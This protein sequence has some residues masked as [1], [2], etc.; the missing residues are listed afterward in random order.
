D[1]VIL[2]I[3]H[4]EVAGGVQRYTPRIV[5]SARRHAR[6]ADDLERLVGRVED[7]DS[8][9]AEFAHVLPPRGIHA[10]VV[11]I[12]QLA[13]ARAGIAV[14]TDKAAIAREDLDPMIAR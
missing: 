7:L 9:V 6:T 5:E 14:G 4:V 8:T 12:T 11:G 2:R 3:R 13:L 1:A 10:D